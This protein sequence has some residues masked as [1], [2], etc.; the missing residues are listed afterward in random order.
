MQ[1]IAGKDS[2]VALVIRPCDIT[3][4]FSF[5]QALYSDKQSQCNANNM[6]LGPAVIRTRMFGGVK[7]WV[8]KSSLLLNLNW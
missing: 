6:N 2:G 1:I 4:L 7:A 3:G 8:G 5:T